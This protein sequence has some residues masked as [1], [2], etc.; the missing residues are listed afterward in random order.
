MDGVVYEN[1]AHF[2]Q[3]IR[4]I[5]SHRQAQ[6]SIQND[7]DRPL[8][9]FGYKDG[10]SEIAVDGAGNM[11]AEEAVRIVAQ[12]RWV[13]DN[14]DGTKEAIKT[15]L[16]EKMPADAVVFTNLIMS[17]LKEWPLRS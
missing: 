15:E 1:L 9:L 6:L 14:K 7:G 10:G 2:N 3:A 4:E 17:C 5:E 11:I 13:Q 8:L 16:E 12:P